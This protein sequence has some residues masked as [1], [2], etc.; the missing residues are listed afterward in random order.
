MRIQISQLVPLLMT[1]SFDIIFEKIANNITWYIDNFI[2]MD[3]NNDYKS[4]GN[5]NLFLKL[6]TPDAW[7]EGF[8]QLTLHNAH[9]IMT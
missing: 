2:F 8:F 5:W 6:T 3:E 9:F 7:T 4:R 1:L